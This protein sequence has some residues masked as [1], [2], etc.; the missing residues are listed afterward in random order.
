[1]NHT[2][3]RAF[4]AVATLGSFS[5]AA[6]AL[7]QTQPAIS[8]QVRRLEQEND[9]LLFLRNRKGVRLTE[10]GEELFRFT[11]RYF[12]IEGEIDGYL[13]ARNTRLS[14]HLR[15]VADSAIHVADV[16]SRFRARHPSVRVTVRSGNTER[17][18]QALRDYDAEIGVVG[19]LP[20][21]GDMEV[22]ELGSSSI[23]A[24]AHKALFDDP[25]ST[26]GFRQLARY[27]LIFREPGS[28]T[29][30]QVLEGA[31]AAGVTLDP[32]FEAEGREAVRSIALSRGGIGFVSKAEH[33][34]DDRLIE[35]E[36]PDLTS[37]MPEAV[38]HLSRRGDVRLIRAFMEIAR[39]F[40]ADKMSGKD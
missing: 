39:G 12:E 24:I 21:A 9:I 2:Q 18:V 14:G 40:R 33:S 17:V 13:A 7:F 15:L 29:R 37:R 25:P 38:V 27:P 10:P 32:V 5:K 30:T 28:R 16:L 35:M 19:S 11:K 23:I 26:I 34:Y 1:M 36:I 22:L 31:R 3:L 6:D 4:H 20:R 8:E